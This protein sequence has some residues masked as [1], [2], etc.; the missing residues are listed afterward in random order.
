[1]ESLSVMKMPTNGFMEA[2]KAAALDEDMTN[3][4]NGI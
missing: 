2:K 1:L 3:G 4:M